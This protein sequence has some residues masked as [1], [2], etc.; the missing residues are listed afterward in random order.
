MAKLSNREKAEIVYS[1][2]G[3][4]DLDLL[5]KIIGLPRSSYYYA[6]KHPKA[7]TRPD[8]HEKVKE[9][10]SRTANGCG[11]RQILMRLRREFDI[12]ISKKTVLKVMRE[13]GLVCKIRR[14]GFRKYSSF[15]GV[16]NAVPNLIARDFK[17]VAPFTKIGTDV[18]EFALPFG[19]V[20]LAQVVDFHSNEILAYSISQS[21]NM[22]QQKEMFD[23]MVK[24]LPPETCPILH[25]D[26]GWQYQNPAWIRWTKKHNVTRSMSRKGNC[27]DN[28]ATEQAFGHM[29]DEFFKG[30]SW[31]AFDAF[32]SDLT[33]YITHWNT[34][35][36]QERL[37]GYAPSEYR[38]RY[39]EAR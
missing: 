29:K 32:K 10:F 18:T 8:V 26:M 15:K 13:L 22:L 23:A 21:P 33:A 16:T 7:A 12:T 30:Q 20:Y 6:R 34:K 35:R 24:V 19:K 2:S 31:D 3:Q 39:V 1:L 9:I 11:H 28:A 25:S 27:L 38:Q 36:P 37:D 4:H 14:K 5:L 17:A